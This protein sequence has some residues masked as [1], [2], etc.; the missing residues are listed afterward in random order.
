MKHP[1]RIVFLLLVVAMTSCTS[2]KPVNLSEP[3][4]MVGTDNGVRVDAEIYGETL[5]AS[6]NIA[7]KV[8][9]TNLRATTILVADLIPEASYDP[10]T[11]M[12]TVEIGSE[13][14]GEQ[15][16]PRLLSIAPSGRR[17]FATGARLVV[18]PSPGVPRGRPNALR[19]RLNFLGEIGPFQTLVD[20]PERAVH[21]PV[22]AAA[23]FNRWV[24]RN[25]TVTTNSLP[26]Q[27]IG[28]RD[29]PVDASR[30]H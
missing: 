5:S 28:N 30:R 1:E 8:D 19:I 18:R 13:I 20:I 22:L 3:R 21:D 25:E 27:W 11:Q 10:E 2:T 6:N 24:E 4:R 17:T 7:L 16:L 12:V 9:V 26:M 23:I 29:S 15:F 14:P